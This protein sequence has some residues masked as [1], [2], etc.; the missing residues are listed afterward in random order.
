MGKTQITRGH[1]LILK[2][3]NQDT[4]EI[5]G[6]QEVAFLDLLFETF[7]CFYAQTLCRN[8]ES[9][10]NMKS[11]IMALCA[12]TPRDRQTLIGVLSAAQQSLGEIIRLSQTGGTL[13][14]AGLH[15]QCRLVVLPSGPQWVPVHDYR[16]TYIDGLH[17][18]DDPLSAEDLYSHLIEH[19]VIFR[20]I[21]KPR[22]N[23]NVS[24]HEVLEENGFALDRCAIFSRFLDTDYRKTALIAV[25]AFCSEI[26]FSHLYQ[27]SSCLKF[28][29]ALR[30]KANPLCL[31]CQTAHKAK[32]WR[33][34]HHE[35][36]KTY[37][38]LRKKKGVRM[39]KVTLEQVRKMLDKDHPPE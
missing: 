20:V 31:G 32:I 24:I 23:P 3:L 6:F 2:L 8:N 19:D 11:A 10:G 21:E 39:T 38:K 22:H 27:C 1:E 36:S 28:D 16:V 5:H 13:R 9:T 18:P 29:V 33:Q 15:H 4:S 14:S 17:N 37:D 25:L 26:D 34:R 12:D 7:L 35:V 30:R